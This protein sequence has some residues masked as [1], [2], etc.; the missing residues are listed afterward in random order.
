MHNVTVEEFSLSLKSE[1]HD[2]SVNWHCLGCMVALT[3]RLHMGCCSLVFKTLQDGEVYDFHHCDRMSQGS[4]SGHTPRQ[5]AVII[6]QFLLSSITPFS[7]LLPCLTLY[8]HCRSLIRT[9]I[10]L[11]VG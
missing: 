1:S 4:H 6:T 9:T 5:C 11:L 10:P 3:R 8:T 2:I 7:L